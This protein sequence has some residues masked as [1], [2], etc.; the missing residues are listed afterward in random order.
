MIYFDRLTESHFGTIKQQIWSF[1]HFP[2]HLTLVLFLSGV[3]QFIIWRQ[4]VE[5]VHDFDAAFTDIFSHSYANATELVKSIASTLDETVWDYIPK[6][7]NY[8]DQLDV[9]TAALANVT[10]TGGNRTLTVDL[11]DDTGPQ[12]ENV[13]VIYISTINIILETLGIKGAKSS[14]DDGSK[15]PDK[16]MEKLLRVIDIVFNYFFITAGIALILIGVLGVMSKTPKK[17]GDYIR[18][19][20]NFIL[21]LALCLLSLMSLTPAEESYTSSPWV[22]P[23]LCLVLGTGKFIFLKIRF[24]IYY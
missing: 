12:F 11:N 1:I 2:L 9:V 3:S 19:S 16:D 6:D 14:K 20:G 15:S 21:G 23:T 7:F 24:E 10:K 17:V 4:A 5:A 8:Q 22:L 13:R 18:S